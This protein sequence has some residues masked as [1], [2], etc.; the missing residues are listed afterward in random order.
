MFW[1]KRSKKSQL[2][3]EI[4]KVSLREVRDIEEALEYLK[5]KHQFLS[6]QHNYAHVCLLCKHI[7]ELT[8]TEEM[9]IEEKNDFIEGINKKPNKRREF[10]NQKTGT[11]LLWDNKKLIRINNDHFDL[12]CFK[13]TILQMQKKS[14]IKKRYWAYI[15]QLTTDGILGT[16]KRG[17]SVDTFIEEMKE[18]NIAGRNTFYDYK[19]R[20]S[21]PNYLPSS[22]DMKKYEKEV[23][24]IKTFVMQFVEKYFINLNIQVPLEDIDTIF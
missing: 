5:W 10:I 16:D 6:K 4:F 23:V 11:H 18:L 2:K 14:K 15:F 3:G 7:V 9:A 21:Y 8:D 20:G 17:I 19:P 1:F 12:T 24:N 22:K 13:N